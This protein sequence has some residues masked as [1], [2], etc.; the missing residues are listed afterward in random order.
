MDLFKFFSRKPSSKDVATSRLKMVIAQDRLN[1]SERDLE[2]M[3][4]DIL[5]VIRNYVEIDEDTLDI[6]ISKSEGSS[7]L[8]ANIPVKKI[9][10]TME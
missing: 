9:R 2:L 4:T 7:V 10:K 1:M 6:Q 3:K 8:I 5:K